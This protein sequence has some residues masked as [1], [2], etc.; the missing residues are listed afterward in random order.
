[1][2]STTEQHKIARDAITLHGAQQ[3]QWELEQLL[4]LLDA[5]GHLRLVVEIGCD[6][7]GTL[8]LWRQT[9]AEVIAVT[10]HTRTD[11]VFAGH[12][13]TV[14]EGD[15]RD[16]GTRARLASA[17]GDRRPDLVFIDGDHSAFGASI[18]LL[19][20]LA[21]APAGIIV[22]HD[23]TRR[24]DHPAIEAWKPWQD[25]RGGRPYIE[26]VRELGVSPGTGVLFPPATTS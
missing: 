8:W 5:R 2:L 22:M 23:I 21:I 10:L 12:G 1:M 13:A 4:A 7:G 16:L 25:V 26:I 11:G 14:I 20:A 3:D 19:T 24:D 6:Q 18:D 17:I 9:G 15:S